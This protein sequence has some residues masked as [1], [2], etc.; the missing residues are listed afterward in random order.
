MTA[1]ITA[2]VTDEN[3]DLSNLLKGRGINCAPGV[4]IGEEERVALGTRDPRGA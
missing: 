1:L 4:W 2:T 3:I